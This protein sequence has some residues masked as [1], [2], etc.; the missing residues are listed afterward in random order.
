MQHDYSH[1]LFCPKIPL[2]NYESLFYENTIWLIIVKKRIG[3]NKKNALLQ[4]KFNVFRKLKNIGFYQIK[5]DFKDINTLKS[6]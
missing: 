2:E 4:L 6:F 3:I 5:K 1:K